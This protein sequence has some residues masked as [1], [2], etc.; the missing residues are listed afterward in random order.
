MTKLRSQKFD[1]EIHNN[2]M[3]FGNMNE[4]F[5][6]SIDDKGLCKTAPSKLF[7]NI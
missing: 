1:Y 7:Y 6:E 5:K 3:A 4:I 2:K